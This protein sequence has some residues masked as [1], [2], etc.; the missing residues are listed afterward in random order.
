MFEITE[1]SPQ[2]K[3]SLL[4]VFINGE[5][6]FSADA[7]FI[8]DNDVF[9]GRKLGAAE[10]ENLKKA[11]D[12]RKAVRHSLFL[13]EHRD[14]SKKELAKRLE[15][16]GYDPSDAMS[17]AEY[18][19]SRGYIND[20]RYAER[21]I[22]KKKGRAG[23]KQLL[24]ELKRAGI[25][26]EDAENA[27]SETYSEEDGISAVLREMKRILKGEIP[28]DRLAQKKL[29]NRFIAKGFDYETVRAAFEKYCENEE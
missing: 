27:L 4:S 12:V 17:A 28:E 18:I 5:Y 21:M 15:T 6:A 9:V 16:K 3:G 22:E 26:E 14:F 29:F 24:Y 13:L 11:A 8:A 23:R 2:K 20:G 7:S 25:S 1:I 19:E 10:L